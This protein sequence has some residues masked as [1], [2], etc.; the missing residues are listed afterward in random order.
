MTLISMRQN[1]HTYSDPNYRLVNWMI[2]H[3]RFPIAQ[4]KPLDKSG[5]GQNQHYENN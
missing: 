4:K 2:S 1:P 3:Q 5:L